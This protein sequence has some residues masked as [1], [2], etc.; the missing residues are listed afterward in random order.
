MNKSCLLSS[1]TALI[2]S[3]SAPNGVSALFRTSLKLGKK[4]G[5]EHFTLL[6]SMAVPIPIQ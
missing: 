5:L 2:T 3:G 4:I 6:P 1:Y